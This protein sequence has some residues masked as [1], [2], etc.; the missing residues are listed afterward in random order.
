MTVRL[1]KS[2]TSVRKRIVRRG[3]EW[4]VLAERSD[5]SFGCYPTRAAAARRLAQVE[6]Y[7][8]ARI[9]PLDVASDRRVVLLAAALRRGLALLPDAVSE[10]ELE[11]A[12]RDGTDPPLDLEPFRDEVAEDLALLLQG[13]LLA[14]GRDEAREGR[15]VTKAEVRLDYAFDVDNPRV[16]RWAA[17]RAAELVV[18]I[19]DATREAIRAVVVRAFVEGGHPRD[20]ARSI[21]PLIGLHSR[22]ATAVL[23]YRLR[24]YEQGVPEDRVSVLVSRYHDRLLRAR[25]LNIARTEILRA[26]NAGK[27]EAWMQAFERGIAGRSPEKMWVAASD[28]EQVCADTDGQIV[29]LH[30]LFSNAFGSFEMPPA[31][32]SCRCTAVLVVSGAEL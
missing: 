10:G 8:K 31:H 14:A 21:R 29:L 27:H 26:A 25:A 5:R 15:A 13:Q 11:A 4:C 1:A 30:D 3:G 2:A 6:G 18:E 17:D 23:N 16:A 9:D 12:A 32:P 7:A 24:L 22:W 28:A 20:V 19:D